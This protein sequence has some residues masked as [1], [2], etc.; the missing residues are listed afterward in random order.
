MISSIL[1]GLRSF[2]QCR[3]S[4][5]LSCSISSCTGA[6]KAAR[7]SSLRSLPLY[8]SVSFD[9]WTKSSSSV[10]SWE[11]I[12]LR[13]S[14]LCCAPGTSIKNDRGIRRKIA[15]SIAHG[16]FVA[17]MTT[18]CAD[19]SVESPSHRAMNS[20]FMLQLASYS[21]S[22]LSRRK[23]SI[24][25]IKMMVGCS[26]QA[27][28]KTARTNFCDSPNHLSCSVDKLTF[29]NTARVSLAMAFASIVFPVPGGP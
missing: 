6:N 17:P 1:R 18:T 14:S 22:F 9:S 24:S 19:D 25:S 10:T 27:K 28:V 11:R 16:R 26:F 15:L 29:R 13:I 5:L 21:P 4:D 2:E 23:E 20:D 3:F 8:P 12:F 7:Q